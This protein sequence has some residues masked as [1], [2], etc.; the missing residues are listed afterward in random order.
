M[1]EIKEVK[2]HIKEHGAVRVNHAYIHCEAPEIACIYMDLHSKR[3][4]EPMIGGSDDGPPALYFH[5]GDDGIKL[6]ESKPRDSLTVVEFPEYPGWSVFACDG[7]ARYTVALTLVKK[8][9]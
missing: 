4:C 1:D 2:L 7:P 6:D 8:H 5:A 3:V 9:G